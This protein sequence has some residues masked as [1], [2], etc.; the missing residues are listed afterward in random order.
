MAGAPAAAPPIA[1]KGFIT[2]SIMLAAVMQT[3]DTT[4][5]NV[6]LP[7]IQGSVSASQDQIV[8]VLT[9]YIVAAAIM[10]PM[11]GYLTDRF[12]IKTVFLWSVAG[13]TLASMLCGAAQNLEQLVLFRLLQGVGGAALMPLTQAVLFSINPP[14][15]YG[16]AMGTFGMAVILGPLLGPVLGGWLTENYSWRWVFYINLPIGLAA[17]FGI[18]TFLPSRAHP[19]P[20]K[21]D[22]FGYGTLALAIASL[23]L[24]MDRGQQNDW[25]QSPETFAEAGVAALMAYLF[26]V[27][28]F[29]AE[30]PF[31]S[32]AL[33]RDRNFV[34]ATVASLAIMGVLFGSLALVPPMMQHLYGYPVLTTGIITMPRGLGTM[35]SMLL[36]GRL[37]GRIDPRLL[38]AIGLVFMAHSFWEMSHFTLE[39]GSWPFVWTGFEQ[40]AAMGLVFVPL[41][42][43]GFGTVPGHLRVEATTVYNIARNI[44]GSIGISIMTALLVQNQQKIH[45]GLASHVRPYNPILRPPFFASDVLTSERGLSML[46]GVISKQAAFISY[47]N[48][49]WL[50]AIVCLGLL[51]VLLLMQKPR[52]AA[53]AAAGVE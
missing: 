24:M 38:M 39:M 46:N 49:F 28:T 8:W 29:T 25:F 15:K 37:M 10:T 27:H 13:F 16:Q 30:R 2:A 26:L 32:K 6:A 19:N 34:S 50:M 44:G 41:S 4:I 36:V 35:L 18:F 48:D 40:G 22:F 11:T 7:H 45:A 12:G 33:F 43:V 47:L 20:P 51:P 17:L 21:F 14:E 3:L 1:N 53:G 52:R 5:A 9:S 31:F 23:Q 42:A